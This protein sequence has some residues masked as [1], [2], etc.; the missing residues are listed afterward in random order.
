MAEAGEH[1][2]EAESGEEQ[3]IKTVTG[4]QQGGKAETEEKGEV[5]AEEVGASVPARR[6]TSQVTSGW[7]QHQ[8]S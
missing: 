1:E 2:V 3:V 4:A 5:E 8:V 6:E 7:Q